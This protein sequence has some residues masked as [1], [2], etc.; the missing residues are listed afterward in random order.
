MSV[1]LLRSGMEEVMEIDHDQVTQTWRKALALALHSSPLQQFG[2][3]FGI[4][5][6]VANLWHFSFTF[7]TP[8]GYQGIYSE[9]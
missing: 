9:E 2:V 1:T 6:Y 3:S 5:W 4:G 8:T 7:L